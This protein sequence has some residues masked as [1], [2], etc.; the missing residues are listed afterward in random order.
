MS[1]RSSDRGLARRAGLAAAL[2]LATAAA[3]RGAALQPI[4]SI[5]ASAMEPAV[6]KQVE[7]AQRSLAAASALPAAEAA[8]SFGEAGK[9][10]LAYV[11][12][13]A[14]APCFENAAALAPENFRWA[15]YGGIAAKWRGDLER[16]RDHFLRA[17][18][19]RPPLP[20][21]QCR[22]GEVEILRGDLESA[23]RAFTA[24]LAFPGVAAAAHFGL[25]RVA[26][27]RG[28]AR[29]AV[30]HLEA[31]LAAQPD[32]SSVHALLA[33]AYRRLGQLDKAKAQAAAYGN[34]RVQFPDP[35]MR[36]VRAANVGKW[37]LIAGA[38]QVGLE[39]EVARATEGRARSSWFD[40]AC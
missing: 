2:L 35:E 5:D 36:E 28:D 24:A 17:I 39:A 33:N 32:A 15:Y 31:A 29:L 1:A 19:L 9:I 14:A 20:A 4:P 21:A 3:L 34:R 40:T 25:G 27:Q 11:L 22:L 38:T 8:K 26:L 7:A 16:A 18:A 37:I 30:E 6:R 10:F 12:L 23:R 13:D